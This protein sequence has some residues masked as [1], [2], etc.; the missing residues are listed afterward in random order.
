MNHCH[1]LA[2]VSHIFIFSFPE[3]GKGRR[4]ASRSPG[5]SACIEIGG[6]Q[7]GVV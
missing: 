3:L 5:E 6:R 1:L 4:R 7:G 2:E